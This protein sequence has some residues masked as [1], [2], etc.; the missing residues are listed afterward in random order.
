MAEA[1]IA[2]GGGTR[3]NELAN[4]PITPGYCSVLVNVYDAV[5]AAIPLIEVDCLDGG[6]WRNSHT[7]ERGQVLITCNSGSINLTA[8]NYSTQNNFL[9]I[10]QSGVTR[11]SITAPI[12]NVIAVNMQMT[13]YFDER[14]YHAMTSDPSDYSRMYND[15]CAIRVANYTNFAIGGGGGGGAG[16]STSSSSNRYRNN[17]GAGGGGGGYTF[18]NDVL[19]NKSQYYKFYVGAGGNGG[20]AT[21]DGSTGASATAFGYT[22]TG[23]GGGR[24]WSHPG[25]GGTGMYNGGN[26]GTGQWGAGADRYPSRDGSSGAYGS[27]GG[28]GGGGCGTQESVVR[29]GGSPYGG[30]GGGYGLSGSDARGGGGGGGGAGFDDDERAGG[31]DGGPG[32]LKFSFY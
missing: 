17:S 2:R 14:E 15:N 5:G 19:I 21:A 30:N 26:G 4:V 7:N 22:V 32:I 24:L 3:T 20:V 11:N 18:M 13:N 29:R 1:I 8:Q 10:D 28:G 27:W 16:C 12:N 6:I 31:G 9:I 25:N 23:G